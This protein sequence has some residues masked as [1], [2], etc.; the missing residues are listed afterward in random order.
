M[1]EDTIT[2]SYGS[3]RFNFLNFFKAGSFSYIDVKQA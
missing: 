3:A 2:V 1:F